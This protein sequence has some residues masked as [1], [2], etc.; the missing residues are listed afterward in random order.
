M[1]FLGAIIGGLIQGMSFGKLMKLLAKTT[2]N[3]QKTAITICCLVAMAM[4]MNNTGMTNDI[5]KFKFW[6]CKGDI[7]LQR[8]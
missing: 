4:L 7:I 6:Q 2:L 5:S 8:L 3:L 1:I